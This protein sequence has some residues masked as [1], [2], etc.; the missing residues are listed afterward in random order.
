MPINSKE[1]KKGKET[2]IR[3]GGAQASGVIGGVPLQS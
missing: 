1:E 2:G 3:I